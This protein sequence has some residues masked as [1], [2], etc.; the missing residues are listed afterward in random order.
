[1]NVIQCGHEHKMMRLWIHKRDCV[2][3]CEKCER[4]KLRSSAQFCLWICVTFCKINNILS[5][6]VT[7]AMVY[8]SLS[9]FHLVSSA[10]PWWSTELHNRA[11]QFVYRVSTTIA[12][13]RIGLSL[14]KQLTSDEKKAKEE[15]IRRKAFHLL[16]KYK[17]FSR[18]EN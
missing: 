3:M 7:W 18:N 17:I 8:F 5:E 1:M 16:I 4:V 13:Y 11:M 14:E 9:L 6:H 10:L 15:K 12:K 2:D